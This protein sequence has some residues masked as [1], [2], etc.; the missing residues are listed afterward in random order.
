MKTFVHPFAAKIAEEK[1]TSN[2]A[3]PLVREIAHKYGWVPPSEH[4]NDYLFKRNREGK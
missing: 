3:F 2:K 4:R 1:V